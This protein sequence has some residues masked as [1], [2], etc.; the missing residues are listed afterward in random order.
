MST[1]RPSPAVITRDTAPSPAWLRLAPGAFLLLWSLGFPVAKIS[2]AYIDP[3]PMLSLRYALALLVLLPLWCWRRPPLPQRGS[4]W[5]HLAVVGLLMQTLYFGCCYM[6]YAVGASVG[7]VALIISLQPILVA[8]IAPRLTGERIAARHWLG[9]ALGLGGASLVILARSSLATTALP[10]IA[11]AVG[12]LLGMSGATL[13]E[14]RFGRA[15]HPLTANAVQYAV[16]LATTLPLTFLIGSWQIDWTPTLI[17]A[18]GY[19]VIGNSLIAI[20]LLLAMIRHSDVTRVS[21][22]FYLV[23]PT[24][25]LLAWWMIGEPIPPLAW[26]GMALA[27]LGVALVNRPRE[28]G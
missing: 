23:P 18:L 14:K 28:H 17:G 25:A 16:G 5:L 8:L 13:Y 7:M 22:L 12:A 10:G 2:V 9:L 1:P 27:S 24:A 11:L 4:D 6:A 20:S 19:L 26:A 15:H 3:L 21:A